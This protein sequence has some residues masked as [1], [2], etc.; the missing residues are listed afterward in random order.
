VSLT[1]VAG[2]GTWP[3]KVQYFSGLAAGLVWVH[4]ANLALIWM[5][6]PSVWFALRDSS[7]VLEPHQER[8]A[9]DV[10]CGGRCPGA[11]ACGLCQ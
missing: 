9:S 6:V 4:V 8:S 7:R 2:A 1:G 10:T 11:L 3:P 5:A